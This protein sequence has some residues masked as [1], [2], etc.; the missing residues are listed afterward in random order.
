MSTKTKVLICGILPP[1][2]F[3]HSMIYKVLLDS[4]FPQA[5]EVTFFNMNFWSYKHHKKVTIVKILK[6][7][8]FFVQFFGVTELLI[9]QINLL[10]HDLV[11]ILQRTEQ[12][13]LP[14][15]LFPKDLIIGAKGAVVR[16]AA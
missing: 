4:S 13:F 10:L 5:F 16:V 15:D 3:G 6:M 14:G 9:E 1:P 7:V 2:Y 8:Q 12:G 11:A